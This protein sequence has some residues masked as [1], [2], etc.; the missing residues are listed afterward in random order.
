MP[1]MPLRHHR[2]LL[3]A[4]CLAAAALTTAATACELRVRWNADPP[5]SLRDA[6]GRIVGLQAELVERTLERMGCRAVWLELPWARALLELHAGRLD[7][8]PGAL[9]RPEREAYAY[10][11]EQHVAVPNRLYVLASRRG[12]VGPATRL[13]QLNLASF[14]LGVQIGVVYGPEYGDLLEDP[15]FRG[16]LTQAAV[17]SKLWQMLAIGRVDGVLASEASA[18]WELAELG[19]AGTVVATDVVLSSEAAQVMFSRRSVEPALVQRY[20]EASAALERDGTLAQI[21]RKYLAD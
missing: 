7:V 12:D 14:R 6:S 21:A 16:R 9:R 4:M 10:W 2:L 3:T 13:R 5:Y 17:R 8:L 18:R 1:G 19:L 20:R 11:A 15:A